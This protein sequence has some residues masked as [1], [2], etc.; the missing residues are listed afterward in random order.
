VKT[1][2]KRPAS[3]RVLTQWVDGYAREHGQPP[4]RVRNW[5]SHMVLGGAL[6][7]AG[8]DE[9]GRKFTIK[10]GVALE[11]RLR[12]RAR[13]TKDLDL[14][15]LSDGDLAQELAAVLER[16]YQGFSF[17][18]RGAPEVMP[19]GAARVEVSLQYLGKSWGTVQVDVGRQEGGRTEIEMVEAISLSAFGLEGPEALACL[20]L[21]YHVAQKIHA[22]TAPPAGRRNERFR[23]LVDLLLMREWIS[24][25]G[26]VQR[27]CQ[28]VFT[29]R[30]THAWPPFFTPPEHWDEPYRR[31]AVELG[32]GVVDVHQAAFEI[33]S[34][35]SKLDESAEVVSPVELLGPFTATTWFFVVAADGSVRRIPATIGEALYMNTLAEGVEIPEEWQREPGGVALIGAVI[36]LQNR[37]PVYVERVQARG[38][39]LTDAIAGKPIAFTPDIWLALAEA[40]LR[41]AK[42][43]IRAVNALA[44]FVSHAEGRL[45][46]MLASSIVVTSRDAHRYFADYFQLTP[47][48]PPLWDLWASLPVQRVSQ[49]A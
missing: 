33:R 43:P 23:D 47:D 16:P 27:A 24:D 12:N 6:E 36:I 3:A 41:V 28:E 25:F 37:S 14:V 29:L 11:L 46:C 35:I 38:I 5:V 48:D 42:A 15:L 19:N 44:V 31:M 7:R 32:L 45:P 2:R 26:T 22:M 21:P 9:V 39:P 20:S 17:R 30:G 10:G 40:I 13:A 49:A 18:L 34:L 1:T 8:F 4:A